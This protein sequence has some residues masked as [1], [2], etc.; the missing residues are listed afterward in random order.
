M[1]FLQGLKEAG[2]TVNP[3]FRVILRVDPFWAERPE[4]EKAFGDGLDVET[5]SLLTTDWQLPYRHPRY[6]DVNTIGMTALHNTFAEEEREP[7]TALKQRGVKAHVFHAFGPFGNFDPVLGIPFPWLTLEKLKAMAA[8]NVE[9]LAHSGGIAPPSL[10]PWPVNQEVWR[11]FQFDPDLEIESFLHRLADGWVGSEWGDKLVAL[12]RRVE[13]AIRAF[14]PPVHLY[15]VYGFV[16]MRLWVRPLVPDIERI[17]E[18]ERAYYEDLMC[19]TPHNPAR[20]DLMKD[21]LFDLTTPKTAARCVTRMDEHLWDPLQNAL[22]SAGEVIGVL[23]EENKARAV[24]FDLAE[25]LKALHCWFQTQRNV[26]AWIAGV[27]GFLEAEDGQVRASHR[28]GVRDAVLQEFKNTQALLQ[29]WETSPVPFMVVSGEGETDFIYG[30]N[31]G[32]LLRN[33]LALMKDREDDEPFIDSDF[34]WRMSGPRFQ[35]S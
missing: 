1:G 28:A 23:P 8:V 9:C 15:A 22:R 25:R 27:H 6:E 29:L 16:W 14:P 32:D 21:V 2:R 34:M 19:T 26:A 4:M 12:W 33:K 7:L 20:V 11:A 31:F 35:E 30:E 24:F 13:E 5:Q 17:P 18:P 3:D 10:V